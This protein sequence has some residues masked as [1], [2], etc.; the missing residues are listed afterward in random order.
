LVDLT[1]KD[2]QINTAYTVVV[3]QEYWVDFPTPRWEQS[4]PFEAVA[5]TQNLEKPGKPT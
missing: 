5:K 4:D 2:L 3:K 1:V